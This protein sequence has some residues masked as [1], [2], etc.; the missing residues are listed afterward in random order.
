MPVVE[1]TVSDEDVESS[2]TEKKESTFGPG[3]YTFVVME[4][5]L[6]KSKVKE[7]PR[8]EMK[9]FV[10]H[11]D[12][13]FTMFDDVYLTEGSKWRYIQFCK[14]IGHDPTEPLDTDDID[15]KAGTL[16]TKR[17]EGE[18]YMKIG[19]YYSTEAAPHEV[20][21]PFEETSKLPDNVTSLDKDD[22]TP[23]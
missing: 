8:L 2:T 7:T 6:G 17:V 1:F 10:E 18:K 5:T 21:G 11:D 22:D 3:N 4:A 15:G 9:F 13:D 16:R 12:R 20:L 23:F 19:E 14:S